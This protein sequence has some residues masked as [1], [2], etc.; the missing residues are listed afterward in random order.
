MSERILNAGNDAQA[1]GLLN[2]GAFVMR[3]VSNL[4]HGF[5]RPNSWFLS[6]ISC[7]SIE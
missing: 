3:I 5:F 1:R 4:S 7:M 6:T 2:C